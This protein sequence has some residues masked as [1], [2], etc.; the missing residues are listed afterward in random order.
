[1]A[2]YRGQA[3]ALQEL[4]GTDLRDIKSRA[5]AKAIAAGD[6]AVA[7]I[8]RRAARLLGVATASIVN[9]LAPDVVVLG[10]GLVEALEEIYLD[11]VRAAV[12][13]HAMPFLARQVKVRAAKLG[14]RA[15]VMG[16]AALAENAFAGKSRHA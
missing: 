6:Q 7:D 12:A 8:V 10:G 14:D 11:E 2:V 13:D 1:M 4:A 16:A 5:L 3:P 9:L 15:T